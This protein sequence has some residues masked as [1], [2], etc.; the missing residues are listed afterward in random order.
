MAFAKKYS[1]TFKDVEEVEWEVQFE[2]DNWAGAVTTFTPGPAPLL[3]RWNQDDK[4]QPIIGSS[5]DIQFLYETA[6]DDLYTEENQTIKVII[7]RDSQDYWTGFLLPGQ[8]TNRFNQ[9]KSFI[10]ITAS[11][12]LGELKDIKFLD[13]SDDPVY[14]QQTEMEIIALILGKVGFIRP[15]IES[16]QIYE[17][18]YSSAI[19]DSPFV[20]TY[21]YPEMYWDEVTGESESCYQVLFDILKKYGAT[22]KFARRSANVRWMIFR[23]N[24]F[25]KDSI[26]Y[27]QFTP[28]GVYSSNT[29]YTTFNQI[30]STLKYMYADAELT[31]VRGI[32]RCEITVTDQMRANI[33]KN[34]SFETFTFDGSD[35][36]FY[37]TN[38]GATYNPVSGDL[39]MFSNTSVSVPNTFIFITNRLIKPD[40]IR[41]IM[42]FLAVNTGAPNVPTT[43]AIY[44]RIKIG[45]YYYQTDGTWTNVAPTYANDNGLWKYDLVAAGKLTMT[46]YEDISIELPK[47]FENNT[48]G[49]N[50]EIDLRVHTYQ[51]NE[52]G[53]GN[54]YLMSSF[55]LEVQA[56]GDLL[57]EKIY[58]EDNIIS[59]SNIKQDMLRLADSWVA[60]EYSLVDDLFYNTTEAVGTANPTEDWYIKG[61]NPTET[62]GIFLAQL[63]SQQYIAGF[64][65]SMDLFSG[66]LRTALT[67]MATQ[68]YRDSN[69]VD[70]FGYEKTYYPNGVALNVHRLEWNGSWIELAPTYN[71]PSLDWDSHDFGTSGILNGNSLIIDD[72]TIT[73]ADEKGYYEL[74]T[75]VD[76]EILRL[77]ITLTDNGTSD[78]PAIEIDG[79]AQTVDWGINYITYVCDSAGTK[80]LTLGGALND[81][82]DL[83]CVV[84]FYYLTGV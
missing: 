69:F 66:T 67:E 5:A 33:I 65:R 47:I 57:T 3:I 63:L 10:T 54:Y 55:R 31:K 60:D 16:V 18:S 4:Y 30:G 76:T 48:Y 29:T 35:D 2:E 1:I 26:T 74:Y 32:G 40:S 64:R 39:K 38:S 68:A 34:G 81:D 71:D 37:W 25:N 36:P 7:E 12:G 82:L 79:D 14:Y 49:N 24:S 8:Y 59:L 20:Q 23:P 52:G 42:N 50:P 53:A 78:L 6:A 62:T 19:T 70:E 46:D 61:D 56:Q 11:D 15:I 73:G 9:P 58:S 41:I 75:A 43:A 80:E 13:D 77:V 17:D 45:T 21:I 84:D 28:E 51:N 27:R 44:L 72:F 83:Q 22:I